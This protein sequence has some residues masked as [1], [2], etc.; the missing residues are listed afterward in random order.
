MKMDVDEYHSKEI[1]IEEKNVS[2]NVA[3]R[4]RK[5]A[6][7]SFFCFYY[8]RIHLQLRIIFQSM[9]HIK[10]L[11]QPFITSSESLL[12]CQIQKNTR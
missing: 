12:A 10:E 5:T 3:D 1:R 8:R 7:L 11:Q 6:V 9:I 4:V 2:L